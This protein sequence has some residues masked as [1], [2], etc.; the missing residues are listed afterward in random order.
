MLKRKNLKTLKKFMF[1]LTC[2]AYYAIIDKPLIL[3]FEE[4]MLLSRPHLS[5]SETK[6]GRN[7]INVC[8]N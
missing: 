6:K 2:S 1:L 3:G 4:G 5:S 7:K 8:S